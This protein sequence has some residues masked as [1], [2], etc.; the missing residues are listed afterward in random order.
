[1]SEPDRAVMRVLEAYRAAVFARD[2]D[3]LIGL[4]D[5]D[6]RVFDLWGAWSCDGVDG[7]R[8]IVAGW[9]DSLGTDRVVVETDDARTIVGGDLAVAHAFIAFNGVSAEGTPQRAMCNRLTWALARRG[10]A[11]KI[12]HEHTSAPID[13]ETTKALLR[14]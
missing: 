4:Y 13:P 3:A 7:W 11:W 2:V 10:D 12:V 8:V 6:V 5:R 1:M 14:R 9:F